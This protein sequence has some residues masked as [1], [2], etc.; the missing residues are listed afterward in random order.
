VD[1]GSRSLPVLRRPALY[2]RLV[3]LDRPIGIV[4]LLWPTLDALWLAARGFPGWRLLLV[5]VAGTTLTR[6][7][8]CAVNDIADRRFDGH[9]KRTARRVLAS[10]A[11]GVGEAAAVAIVLGLLSAALLPL[12]NGAAVELALVAV[13]VAVSYPF[14]KR[15]F[16][17]PQAWLGVAFSFGIPMAYA[18]VLGEVP[19]EGWWLFGA[20]LLWVV[21]Y[22]TEYAMVDRDDDL[23]L[24]L[25]S[26]AI[27]FG[28]ADVAAVMAC[29]AGYLVLLGALGARAGLGLPFFVGLAAAAGCA[30]Y[31]YRLI[32]DRDRDGCLRA[33]LH[34]HWLGT[35]IFAGIVADYALR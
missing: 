22:D 33:F 31:H 2:A 25:R 35:C 1:A 23:R 9:V 34:N 18:A 11:I 7:A 8:G 16:P 15:F 21:A 5:F 32:R 28:R 27:F 26:S 6:S 10:G 29:Y 14:F 20:N 30:A 12:L 4:L 13:V 17:L 3:R 19:L 24:G